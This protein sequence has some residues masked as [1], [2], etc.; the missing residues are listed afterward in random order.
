MDEPRMVS[1]HDQAAPDDMMT[2]EKAKAIVEFY[3]GKPPDELWGK[4]DGDEKKTLMNAIPVSAGAPGITPAMPSGM[5]GLASKAL[6]YAPSLGGAAKHAKAGVGMYAGYEGVQAIGKAIGLPPALVNVLSMIGGGLGGHM[7][8]GSGAAPGAA[9]EE[10]VQGVPVSALEKAGVGKASINATMNGRSAP[11][12]GEGKFTPPPPPTSPFGSPDTAGLRQQPNVSV[13][14][15]INDVSEQV[16]RGVQNDFRGQVSLK[17]AKPS[18]PKSEMNRSLSA[19]EEQGIQDLGDLVDRT[20]SGTKGN[21]LYRE[22]ANDSKRSIKPFIKHEFPPGTDKSTKPN[23]FE[24]A[25]RDFADRQT[26]YDAFQAAQDKIK[27]ALS[28]SKKPNVHL[29]SRLK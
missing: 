9:A 2:P 19:G 26:D 23:V 25:S 20:G 11:L 27:E 10:M 18:G 16:G 22:S 24:Q 28:R 17:S 7:T 13:S 14:R 3:K 5:V 4:L 15:N 1:S 29:K 8:G 12:P 21:G 6:K